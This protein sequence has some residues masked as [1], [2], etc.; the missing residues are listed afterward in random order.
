MWVWNCLG[1]ND[2]EQI[3]T[4]VLDCLGRACRPTS[5]SSSAPPR[6]VDKDDLPLLPSAHRVRAD[7]ERFQPFRY[8]H[9]HGNRISL[10]H[11]FDIAEGPSSRFVPPPDPVFSGSSTTASEE[12]TLDGA[13]TQLCEIGGTVRWRVPMAQISFRE[14][15]TPR[16][17]EARAIAEWPLYVHRLVVG[18]ELRL[19]MPGPP[20][21][22]VDLRIPPL[23][24]AALRGGMIG[25]P[26]GGVIVPCENFD[27]SIWQKGGPPLDIGKLVDKP[28]EEVAEALERWAR[29]SLS[30]APNTWV[31]LWAEPHP[32]EKTGVKPR[33]GL[34]KDRY[35]TMEN[36]ITG[37]AVQLAPLLSAWGTSPDQS[38]NSNQ[39][40]Q[41]SH[42][43]TTGH[44]QS[45]VYCDKDRLK[46]LDGELNDATAIAAVVSMK[47]KY[48]SFE[49]TY[50]HEHM[51]KLRFALSAEIVSVLSVPSEMV[52]CGEF[53]VS[54]DSHVVLQ[55]AFLQPSIGRSRT[56]SQLHHGKDP[57]RIMLDQKTQEPKRAKK[58]S[59]DL[60][61]L[62]S[63]FGTPKK[64]TGESST[65]SSSKRQSLSTPSLL[66]SRSLD[67]DAS[68]IRG[69]STMQSDGGESQ[70]ASPMGGS[71][72]GSPS[73]SIKASLGTVKALGKLKGKGGWGLAIKG[74]R[75]RQSPVVVLRKFVAALEDK[76]HKLRRHPHLY[77]T[78]NRI[79]PQGIRPGAVF[80][81][82]PSDTEPTATETRK[83][84]GLYRKRGDEKASLQENLLNITQTT[85]EIQN[86]SISIADKTV[87][88]E[89]T[90]DEMT[91]EE[92]IQRVR[93]VELKN[94]VP[95][96]ERPHK[97]SSDDRPC[98]CVDRHILVDCL[99]ALAKRSTGDKR[100]C[101]EVY[102]NGGIAN[103]ANVLNV[104]SVDDDIQHYG[105]RTLAN[106]A[107]LDADSVDALCEN[108]VTS[109]VL[110]ALH[111]FPYHQH[112]QE[113]CCRCI[114]FMFKDPKSLKRGMPLV[115]N[116]QVARDTNFSVNGFKGAA[117]DPSKVDA[118]AHGGVTQIL[119]Q[120]VINSMRHWPL[121]VKVLRAALMA[122]SIIV[123]TKFDTER[124]RQLGGSERV[125]ECMSNFSGDRIIQENSIKVLAIM[126]Q[127]LY[128]GSLSS[129]S[130]ICTVLAMNHFPQN[131][132]LQICGMTTLKNF[133]RGTHMLEQVQRAGGLKVILTCM[134]RHRAEAQMQ[135]E[136]SATLYKFT[137][138]KE[139]IRKCR[140]EAAIST[141]VLGMCSHNSDNAAVHE[142]ITVLEKLCPRA[143]RGFHDI[144]PDVF[145]AFPDVYW[146]SRV[147]RS[148]GQSQDQTFKLLEHYKRLTLISEVDVHTHMAAM[149]APPS[150]RLDTPGPTSLEVEKICLQLK[151]GLQSVQKVRSSDVWAST[152]F[153]AAQDPT[154]QP[155]DVEFFACLLGHWNWHSE[156][157]ASEVWT[158]NGHEVL[159]KWLTHSLLTGG[160]MLTNHLCFPAR[161]ACLSAL[162]SFC[163]HGKE[164][165][166]AVAQL[167]IEEP[168]AE[169]LQHVSAPIRRNA[170]RLLAA[171]LAH[172][173][174]PLKDSSLYPA[175]IR[176]LQDIEPSNQI[177]ACSVLAELLTR[178]SIEAI[179]RTAAKETSLATALRTAIIGSD[180][181]GGLSMIP[182]LLALARLGKCPS[183]ASALVF[184]SSAKPS[185]R[186]A[187]PSIVVNALRGINQPAAA[188]AAPT[189]AAWALG[190]LG[191]H[192]HE[193]AMELSNAGACEAL[194]ERIMLD[195]SEDMQM[196]ANQALAS[197]VGALRDCEKLAQI[198]VHKGPW[199]SRD[200]T[201][202]GSAGKKKSKGF[203]FANHKVLICIVNQILK[204]LAEDLQNHGTQTVFAACE[205]V[206]PIK[207]PHMKEGADAQE[208]RRLL[209][210][211]HRLHVRRF[212]GV[213]FGVALAS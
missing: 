138:T 123:R 107:E 66:L 164:F 117:F 31:P 187:L 180:K 54:G 165:V 181:I 188:V 212:A 178:K 4:E 210:E 24:G 99:Q 10:P 27:L 94:G 204:L 65:L 202:L 171:L 83:G 124:V 55:V 6:M 5:S 19:A 130:I 50:G 75:E 2:V 192:T 108:L 63:L 198:L 114:G 16:N 176:G 68:P 43:D 173:A 127:F 105:I 140:V 58:K 81:V 51:Q 166:D 45:S 17:C 106:L 96:R 101:R 60:T 205:K 126:S 98:V 136:G 195:T 145:M 149:A 129:S 203:T 134:A 32:V 169:C 23:E 189:A 47:M 162:A 152:V 168:L 155:Q 82:D 67:D 131:A 93:G 25:D 40:H 34:A 182:G 109:L 69:N 39:S 103:I 100:A 163:K 84:I 209:S 197:I 185:D 119:I 70:D 115:Q 207:L 87:K 112:I 29:K 20:D 177:S 95:V 97:I 57:F 174:E 132:K 56:E 12:C 191:G 80:V 90:V 154:L 15:A 183:A 128:K 148:E 22:G 62:P 9:V 175:V 61:N 53:K 78:L 37:Q 102:L 159:L 184:P 77:P 158:M 118:I 85:A 3:K 92:V 213:A 8:C 170:L 7:I 72:S 206:T 172:G 88:M 199:S 79:T 193:N 86:L 104:L 33:F 120:E 125:L 122:L 160:D 36:S 139:D 194:L 190:Q 110:F 143:M 211:A 141:I 18:A 11:C 200:V 144:F 116:A 64:S 26:T 1:I 52:M 73:G 46:S 59:M 113:H 153:F 111:S 30:K 38:H 167:S 156:N 133:A 161:C 42:L 28:R 135:T 89:A 91:I 35:G 146:G 14:P 157:L 151:N 44:D 196:H 201:V 186:N 13:L 48:D 74:A 137:F 121:D 147:D 21:A 142:G 76:D 208:L 71:Q 179:P 41:S 49:I 150:Q